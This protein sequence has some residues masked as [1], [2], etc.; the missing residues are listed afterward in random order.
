[1][2][3]RIVVALD[4]PT[5][6]EATGLARMLSDEVGGFKVGMELLMGAGPSAIEAVAALGRPVFADA[7]LHDIPNTVH[8]A[9]ARVRAAGARW[10]TAHA[11]GGPEMLEAAVSGM[12]G[13]GVLAVTMLTSLS[14][15]DLAGIGVPE[16]TSDYVER[17]AGI[18]AEGGVEG[19]VC[20]PAETR[21]VKGRDPALVVFTPGVRPEATP[22]HD[23]K[24]VATPEEARAGGADYLVIGRPITTAVDPVEAVRKIAA[25]I[26]AIE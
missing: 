26:A 5:L 8:K 16:T 2:V 24:R 12:G 15:D 18:A 20:S 4:V 21:V 1:M 3:N 14:A 13:D 19:V 17:M 9:A 6:D 10:V 23:Q 25:S 7:K 11:A 22:S